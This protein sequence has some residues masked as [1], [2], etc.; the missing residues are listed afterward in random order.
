MR[1]V[2]LEDLKE[3][4]YKAVVEF[5][6]VYYAVGNRQEHVCDTCVAH[7]TLLLRPNTASYVAGAVAV[8]L[9]AFAS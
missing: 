2:T 4:P 3:S 9:S 7:V 8:I 1:N 6:P 5:D